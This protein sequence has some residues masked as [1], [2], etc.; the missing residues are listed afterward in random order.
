MKF[1]TVFALSLILVPSVSFSAT[2]SFARTLYMGMRGEDVRELQKVLNMD[3]ET[4]VAVSG[5]GSQGNET[6][7]FGSATKRALVKFQ[8]KYRTEILAPLGLT[9]GTGVFGEKTR[10]KAQMFLLTT[11]AIPKSVSM[12]TT[13]GASVAVATSTIVEKG[14]VFVY[15]PSQYSGKPGTTITISGLGFTPTNNTI[16]FDTTHTVEKVS[17][18]NGQEI[19]FKIPVMPKGVYHLFVKNA[20]GESNKN[21]FFVVT[22]GVTAEPKIE[23]ITPENALRGGT[24]TV[25]GSGFTQTGNMARTGVRVFENI[26]SADGKSLSFIIPADVLMS[27]TA[28]FVKKS[29]IPVWVYMV[30]ENG[31]SNGKSFILE[32]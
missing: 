23:S 17:S 7:Y 31:I 8:E 32:L 20:R 11:P 5:Y 2:D 3:A 6:D 12:A 10:A 29:S 18:W 1:W 16:Y 28:S 27:A 22:D 14:A 9:Y 15:F 19:T 24:I 25:K 4:R 30:N 13:T 26:S 21:A